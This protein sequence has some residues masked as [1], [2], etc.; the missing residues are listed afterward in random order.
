MM[1]H[2]NTY[3]DLDNTCN[4]NP[5]AAGD[6]QPQNALSAMDGEDGNRNLVSRVVE[7]LFGPDAGVVDVTVFVSNE[8]YTIGE[9]PFP[10]P[11]EA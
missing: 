6:F 5:A 4:N 9:R 11:E 1:S 10:V 2:T 8:A 7:D 3:N